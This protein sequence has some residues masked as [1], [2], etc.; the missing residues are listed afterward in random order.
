MT[1]AEREQ[2]AVAEYVVGLMPVAEREAFVRR[3]RSDAALAQRVLDW[4]NHLAP[5]DEEYQAVDVPGAVKTAIDQRLFGASSRQ[6][7]WSH[8]L[9]YL[10]GML[11][12]GLAVAALLVAVGFDEGMPNLVA[13][14]DSVEP[15][16]AFQARYARDEDALTLTVVNGVA[17]GDRVYEIWAIADDAAPVSLGVLAASGRLSLQGRVQLTKGVTLA[18]SL[19]PPGGSPTGAPTG[20]VLSAGVLNNV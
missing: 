3:L 19:E 16:Y 5:L 14:L 15:G 17:P 7:R 9:S 11:A 1:D 2:I 6:G 20:P 13:Q 18:V 4:Q 12:A 8:R 10:S